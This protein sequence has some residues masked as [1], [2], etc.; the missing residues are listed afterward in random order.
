MRHLVLL[1]GLLALTQSSFAQWSSDPAVNLV[2]AN[3]AGDQ[4][5][6]KVLP[7]PD[8]GVY[9]S[10]FDGAGFDVRIQRLFEG[11]TEVFPHDG[12]LVADRGFSSTQDYG[13]AM[14]NAS[15]AL[16]AFRDDRISGTQITAAIVTPT[17]TQPWGATGVQLTST[18]DFL[19]APIIT[20]TTDGGSVV[21]W[22]QEETVRVQKLDAAGNAQWPMDVVL[23]PTVGTYSASDLHAD[24]TDAILSF[25]HVTGNPTAP[26]HLIAQ[27]LDIDGNLL[28]GT[29]HVAV[30]DGGSLQFGNFPDFVP[31]GS[32]GGVFSW[33]DTAGATLECY[34]Q[35][36][37]SNGTEAFTHNGLV[38]STNGAQGRVGPDVAFDAATSEIYVFWTE[39]ANGQSLQGLSGQKIDAAGIRRW[40]DIGL[41]LVAPG[42]GE[43]ASVRTVVG[44]PGA[45]VFWDAAPSFGR[46]QLFGA[47]ASGDASGTI[48]TFTFDV[49]TTPSGK[50]RLV[51][52]NSTGGFAVLAWQDE[53]SGSDDIYA[54]NVNPDGTLGIPVGVE[55]EVPSLSLDLRALPNPSNGRIQFEYAVPASGNVELAIYDVLGRQVWT[56]HIHTGGG[57]DHVTWDGRSHQGRSIGAGVYFARLRQSGLERSI[58]LVVVR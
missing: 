11:G 35:R 33:Y 50:S 41:E 14:D 30:F 39:L 16:L 27:K 26:K 53:R 5:Q 29:N 22:T 9:I 42:A 19:A 18:S 8:G 52:A 36:I 25:V 17:G 43:I 49:S 23:T 56:Q 34:V 7:T 3:A 45:F 21:S 1:A 40:T 6:P 58:S 48:E 55:S 54:Q 57:R 4:V 24:G 38:V 20:G 31:D 10:W 51:V 44:G 12:I 2:V 15:N 37:L 46:D 32:G 28:W 47:N 13:L